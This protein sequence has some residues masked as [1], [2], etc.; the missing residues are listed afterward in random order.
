MNNYTE[1]ELKES[2]RI[3]EISITTM[4]MNI[5]Y[6]KLKSLGISPQALS[7]IVEGLHRTNNELQKMQN[8]FTFNH[9]IKNLK[10]EE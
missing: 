8:D 7:F 1:E 10:K 9:I 5:Y 2:M 3:I 4:A 6:L